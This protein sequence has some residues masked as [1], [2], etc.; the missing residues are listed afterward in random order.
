[1]LDGKK[2]EAASSGASVVHSRLYESASG[3]LR[4][5]RMRSLS[6]AALWEKGAQRES[7]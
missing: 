1:M 4:D 3:G 7:A 2:W 5:N 6:M